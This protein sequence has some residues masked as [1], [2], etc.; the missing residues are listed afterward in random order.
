MMLDD[1]A[2]RQRL[3]GATIDLTDK[4]PAVNFCANK[5]QSFGFI[6]Q[7]AEYWDFCH[8]TKAYYQDAESVL[9]LVA[10]LMPEDFLKDDHTEGL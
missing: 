8:F 2:A 5:R 6:S 3:R 7:Q 9:C 1:V 4:C 10:K